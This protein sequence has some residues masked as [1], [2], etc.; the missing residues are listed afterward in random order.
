[1][2]T[3]IFSNAKVILSDEV[4]NG[5]VVIED[6]VIT[7]I[8]ADPSAVPA[9]QDMAGDYLMPGLIELHTDNLEGH[10]SPRPKT[11]W[12]STA[13]LLAH[14]GQLA[15]AG[16]T[17]VFDALAIGTLISENVRATRL[18]DMMSA[19]TLA[20]EHALTRVEH[21]VHLRCEISFPALPEILETMIDNHLVKLVSVMD[22]TPGQ[23]QFMD[24]LKYRTYYMGKHGLN[25]SE[26]DE[27]ISSR[28]ASQE[29]YSAKNRRYVVDR[30]AALGLGIASHDDA[31]PEHVKQAI[32]DGMTIAE[33]P[34]TIAAAKASHDGGLAVL[35]GGPN[36][37]RGGSHS[38]NVSAL[39]LAAHGVLNIISSDYVPSSL[40]HSAFLVHEKLPDWDLPRAI[41]TV[42]RA[43]AAATGLT[44]RGE[45][46]VGKRADLLRVNHRYNHPLVKGVWRQGQRVA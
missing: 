12:P 37:V 15:S 31:T 10:M 23:R 29:I 4:I 40:L 21:L 33:F 17:T 42:T 6:G 20:D 27:F 35:M 13:A 1:M 38:G 16:I 41:A 30:A 46:A 36:I 5:T 24:E 26:M 3:D 8:A 44:D 25:E 39:E 34:T 32:D 45:I 22:H 11:D 2:T 43:P 7:D 18:H 14:D 9:A 19:I 28:K